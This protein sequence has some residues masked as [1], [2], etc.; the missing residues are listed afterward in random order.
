MLNIL[1]KTKMTRD[2]SIKEICVIDI[3][4]VYVEALKQFTGQQF[5]VRSNCKSSKSNLTSSLYSDN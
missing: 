2:V 3:S 4:I 5:V 1:I